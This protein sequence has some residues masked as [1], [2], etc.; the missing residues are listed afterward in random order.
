MGRETA[1]HIH[2][3][4]QE[5][6]QT[7]YVL[8]WVAVNRSWLVALTSL[9]LNLKSDSLCV[10]T[11]SVSFCAT[12]LRDVFIYLDFLRRA[13][14]DLRVYDRCLSVCAQTCAKLH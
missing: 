1:I 10:K 12:E 8:R 9:K 11:R 2:T 7:R 4:V 5:Y 6:I 3:V 14:N 13:N